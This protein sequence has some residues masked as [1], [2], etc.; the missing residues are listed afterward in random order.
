MK[1]TK[2]Y[3]IMVNDAILSDADLKPVY[4]KAQ[5]SAQSVADFIRADLPPVM[6]AGQ[7]QLP[8]VLTIRQVWLAVR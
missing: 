6:G 5:V 3:V 8:A 2:R 1:L 4:F 7:A